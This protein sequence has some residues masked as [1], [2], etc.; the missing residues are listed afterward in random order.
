MAEV[1]EDE[2]DR[3]GGRELASAGASWRSGSKLLLDSRDEVEV[4]D[5]REKTCI[6]IHNRDLS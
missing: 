4:L 1:H 6:L 2:L 5:I 3:C